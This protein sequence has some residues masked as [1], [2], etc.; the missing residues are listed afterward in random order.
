MSRSRPRASLY[1]N[2]LH[3]YTEAL[4]SAVPIPDPQV[5][6]RRIMLEGDVPSPVHP[7]AGCRFHTRCPIAKFPQCSAETPPLKESSEG[8]WVACHFR[9]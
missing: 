4:L 7:P 2:P 6:R 9:G 5:K 8:H 3:P 1:A